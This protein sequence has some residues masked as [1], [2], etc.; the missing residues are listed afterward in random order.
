MFK[1]YLK[2]FLKIDKVAALTKFQKDEHFQQDKH[3]FLE[4]DVSK[5]EIKEAGERLLVTLYDWKASSSLDQ[6]RLYKFNQKIA[7]N[8]KVVQPDYLYPTSDAAVFHSFRVC[9]EVQS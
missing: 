2:K 7:S 6:I 5:A 8:N 9:Y 1:D 4:K 3:L